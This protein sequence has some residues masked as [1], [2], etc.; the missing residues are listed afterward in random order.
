MKLATHEQTRSF[1]P[2][3]LPPGVEP[4]WFSTPDGAMDAVQDA[5]IGWLD[6]IRPPL[7]VRALAA[8]PKLKWV[9]TGMSGVNGLPL[10]TF[11]ARG[12]ALTNGAGVNAIPVAE[13]AVMG[14]FVLAKNFPGVM[15]IQ[16]ARV[17][18]DFG[19]PA[20]G[21]GELFESKAL[22]I[23]Y[24]AIGQAIGD[25]IRGLGVQATPVRRTANRADGVLGPD[26][27]RARLGEFDWVIVT[28]PATAET[29]NLIGAAELAAMKPSAYVL[30]VARGDSID[31]AALLA[32]VNAKRIAGAFLDVVLPEPAPPDDPVWSTPGVIMTSHLSGRSQTRMRE[33][34]AVLFLEN[35]GRYLKGEPL[36]NLVDLDQ[37]Y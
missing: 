5:E 22:I 7:F 8:G 10:D 27:W 19:V 32:A 25:R 34:S 37:G 28:A 35:L 30:N 29:R 26:D 6:L 4:V 14:M 13:Y 16:E 3:K 18:P 33:R 11:K 17:W 15:K 21:V 2:G 31:Q 36:R 23:G 9:S 12:I 20:P 1:L 24:G